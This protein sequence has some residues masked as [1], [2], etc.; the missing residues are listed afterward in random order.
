MARYDVH[1]TVYLIRFD[2]PYKHAK[3]YLGKPESLGLLEVVGL[4]LW[5][6]LAREQSCRHP[7]HGTGRLGQRLDGGSGNV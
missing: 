1:G 2:R 3:H 7:G 5:A 6:R 4:E